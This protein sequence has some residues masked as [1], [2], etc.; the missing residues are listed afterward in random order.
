MCPGLSLQGREMLRHTTLPTERDEIF[1]SMICSK[2]SA[3]LPALLTAS[4]KHPSLRHPR[5]SPSRAGS[6]CGRAP[7]PVASCGVPR[8]AEPEKRPTCVT[9]V[10]LK[11]AKRERVTLRAPARLEGPAQRPGKGCSAGFSRVPTAQRQLAGQDS[12]S[13]PPG[14]ARGA[15]A[16]GSKMQH[17]FTGVERRRGRCGVPSAR[18]LT[19][20]PSGL[21]K[22]AVCH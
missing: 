10:L 9:C 21:S 11:H 13:P 8:D 14:G 16:L 4:V 12:P 1:Q 2:S 15:E 17:A 18:A 5:L 3:S 7:G 6:G 22:G 20:R 19:D